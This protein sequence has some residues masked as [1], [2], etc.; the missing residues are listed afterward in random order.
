[1]GEAPEVDVSTQT[2]VLSGSGHP[3]EDGYRQ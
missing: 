1:M 2:S 3:C